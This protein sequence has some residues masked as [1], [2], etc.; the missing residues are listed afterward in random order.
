[1][2]TLEHLPAPD[3]TSYEM[4]A[5]VRPGLFRQNLY[6]LGHGMWLSVIAGP[7]TYG[8]GYEWESATIEYG[9]DGDV[10]VIT[11]PERTSPAVVGA[12]VR[13]YRDVPDSLFWQ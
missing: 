5:G 10:H 12:I 2:E 9:R 8:D 4:R 1:M 11:E 3:R 13:A 6:D 7:D